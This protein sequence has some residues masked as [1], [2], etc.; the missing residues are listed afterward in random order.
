MPSPSDH[1]NLQE[2]LAEKRL[3]GLWRLMRGYRWIYLGA[4]V[5]LALGAANKT[6]TYYLLRYLVDD[7]LGQ[8]RFDMTLIYVGLGFVALALGEGGFTFLSGRL[9]AQTSEGLA[10]R[11]RNFL[12][13]HLQRLSFS[14]HDR[15]HTG[16]LIQRVTSDVDA[17]RRFFAQ[18]AIGFGRVILLF[19][20]NFTGVW[21]INPTLAV[22]SVLVVPLE[23]V[24]SYFFFK[25]ISSAYQSYQDQEA[26]LSNTLQE[27]LTGV[28]VVKAFARQEYE[29]GKFEGDNRQRFRLGKKLI[30][31]HSV[32][33]PFSDILASA[34]LIGGFA[35]GGILTINGTITLGSFLAYTGMV[36]WIVW[37]MR[38]LGRLIVQMS[39]AL[40]SYDRVTEIISQ[41]QEPL[42]TGSH[43][44]A[45]GLRGDV[46]FHN[47]SFAYDS[48][49]VLRDISFH[50][51]PGQT[52]ALMG[53]T[54][55]GKTSVV[56]LLPRFYEVT[57]GELFIDGVDIR[58]YPR[59]YLR[60]HIGIVEQE[61]FLFSRTIRE[62]ITYGV[63]REV[64]DEEVVV[65]ARA[66]A[67]HDVIAAF[68]NGYET[69]V[70]ER[71]VTLSG[72]QKQRV[73]LARTL[74]KDP[75]ILILDDATSSVDTE[76]EESI[77]Q[78][79]VRLMENRT[80]FIIAHRVQSV[81]NA[82]LILVLEDGR[83]IQRGTHESLL[84]QPGTYREIYELQ[85][86]IE[87]EL[88]QELTA[89]PA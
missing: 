54:G 4:V 69:L 10:R 75:A 57:G 80:T 17:V 53:Y 89:V 73:A 14:Y 60:R 23:I 74:L 43:A 1:F 13:D 26:K 77:H 56:N 40:V 87:E 63:G 9:A 30:L 7:V 39:Q 72:G 20:V 58:Q 51:L 34:Q 29:R 64:G 78:A 19:T 37:P 67:I 22:V 47:V 18:E 11:L 79:L 27:N 16:E 62:N 6:A 31:L 70:G 35:V 71:G 38:V 85:S 24:M 46:R 42:T 2:T 86:R 15:S 66:A 65:A 83:I 33:W 76:T 81:M 84:A 28:R 32:Y 45:G 50:C 61:P 8:G 36:I 25:R 88:E 49:T 59:L 12:Y 48:T 21:I 55:S 3:V 68:P 5:T 44:P 52:V 41:E 82:D